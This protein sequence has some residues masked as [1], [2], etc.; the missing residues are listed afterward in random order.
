MK[1]TFYQFALEAA[2]DAQRP[3]AEHFKNELGND[4]TLAVYPLPT[5]GVEGVMIFIRGPKSD[6]E[7][8][9]TLE[10]A[11][12]LHEQLG[13]VLAGRK[14]VSVEM[15]TEDVATEGKDK[16]V[17]DAA[18]DRFH[19]KIKRACIAIGSAVESAAKKG[20]DVKLSGHT[21]SYKVQVSGKEPKSGKPSTATW[22]L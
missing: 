22:K 20:F 2:H 6:T 15:V 4:I 14:Q 17:S 11:H 3:N 12:R 21:D 13:H 19:D 18:I 9:I 5:D 8:H 10:E 1:K 7:N 16:P